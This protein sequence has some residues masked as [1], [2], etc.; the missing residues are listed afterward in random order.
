MRRALVISAR[1]LGVLLAVLLAAVAAAVYLRPDL[2]APLIEGRSSSVPASSP[3]SAGPAG[4]GTSTPAAIGSAAGV[5]AHRCSTARGIVRPARLQ[6]GRLGVDSAV[7]SLGTDASGA[8]A[9]PAPDQGWTAAWYDLGPAPGASAGRAVVSVHTYHRGGA[10]GN[11]LAG[12]LRRGDL[13]RLVASD[14]RAVCYRYR[15][16][17]RIAVAGYD[18]TSTVLYDDGG[19][20]SLGIV[21][22]AGYDAA[23]GV[24]ADRIIMYADPVR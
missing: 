18:R 15:D 4:P 3:S 22:C 2:A 20:A 13:I 10:L 11:L 21:T 17:V 14:G 5:A 7:E 16:S 1:V 12:S 24:W 23:T 6:V 9:A 19:P 8:A